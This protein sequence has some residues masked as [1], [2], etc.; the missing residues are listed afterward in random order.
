[1]P[2]IIC[3]LLVAG[4]FGVAAALVRGCERLEDEED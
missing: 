1:M 3:L 2:D 4:F